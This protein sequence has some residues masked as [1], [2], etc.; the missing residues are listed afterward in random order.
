MNPSPP[1]NYSV[2]LSG[3]IRVLS[4]VT[5]SIGERKIEIERARLRG[6]FELE[7]IR[8]QLLDAAER[9]ETLSVS[10][11]LCAYLS[12][13]SGVEEGI[14]AS[15][16]WYEVAFAFNK[17]AELNRVT[18]GFPVFRN[19]VS[20][21]KDMPWDYEGR[22][23]YEWVHLIASRYGW[24]IEYIAELEIEDGIALIQEI[25]VS[26]QLDKEWQWQM[27]EMAFEYV[28]A[29]KSSKFRP[30]PRPQWMAPKYEPPKSIK[31]R[32]DMLPIGNVVVLDK[33]ASIVH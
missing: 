19:T 9:G 24:S 1:T 23:W 31:I 5:I 14:F 16:V 3:L 10:T 18:K 8:G 11:L 32:K 15:A 20:S 26:D 4:K 13:A 17:V 29:T 22:D 21:S 30:L 33:N 12:A 6:W 27:S 7:K 25:L 2:L 28:P